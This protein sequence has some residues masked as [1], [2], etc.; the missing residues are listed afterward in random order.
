LKVAASPKLNALYTNYLTPDRPVSCEAYL[1]VTEVCAV[2]NLNKD[3]AT[4]PSPNILEDIAT[5]TYTVPLEL[6]NLCVTD[7]LGVGARGTLYNSC[8]SVNAALA[9]ALAME[10]S[11]EVVTR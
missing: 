6:E 2:N 4:E 1:I 9:M 11:Q 10:A 8:R 3:Q 7:T 5:F